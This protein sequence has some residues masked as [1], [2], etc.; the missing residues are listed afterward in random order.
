MDYQKYF[1][2]KENTISGEGAACFLFTTSFFLSKQTQEVGASTPPASKLS[3]LARHRASL[4]SLYSTMQY[5][6]TDSSV[7]SEAQWRGKGL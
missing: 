2:L 4:T 1:W 7:D 5:S 6:S 3:Q